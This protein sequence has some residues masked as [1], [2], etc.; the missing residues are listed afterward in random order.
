MA[1]MQQTYK[2]TKAMSDLIFSSPSKIKEALKKS[3][4]IE[5]YKQ[6]NK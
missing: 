3:I 6:R 2:V 4:L 5:K 1:T